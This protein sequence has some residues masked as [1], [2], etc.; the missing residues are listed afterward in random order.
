MFNKNTKITLWPHHYIHEISMQ[1]FVPLFYLFGGDPLVTCFFTRAGQEI[2][3]EEQLYF[4][5]EAERFLEMFGWSDRPI[6]GAPISWTCGNFEGEVGPFVAGTLQGGL[7]VDLIEATP[8]G[9]RFSGNGDDVVLGLFCHGGFP[10]GCLCMPAL[11]A[12]SPNE[13]LLV[14]ALLMGNLVNLP[15]AWI[16][17]LDGAWCAF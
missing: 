15:L 1:Q 2:P 14:S 12:R 4:V 16:G 3:G 9:D 11:G 10:N 7:C 17:I 6:L 8:P 13:R 5:K